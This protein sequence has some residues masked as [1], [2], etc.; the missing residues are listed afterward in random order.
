MEKMLK[1]ST[2]VQHVKKESE[3]GNNHSLTIQDYYTSLTHVHIL[4]SITTK[5]KLMAIQFTTFHA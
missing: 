5:P 3:E 1:L 2:H 4:M